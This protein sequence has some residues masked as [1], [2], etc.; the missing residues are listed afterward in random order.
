MV[1]TRVNVDEQD[2]NRE[3]KCKYQLANIGKGLKNHV[4]TDIF[5][6]RKEKS[7]LITD[8]TLKNLITDL[9][10]RKYIPKTHSNV[11]LQT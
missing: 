3:S 1:F 5:T 11:V 2:V 4:Y 9:S 7:I 10:V 6:F 8:F